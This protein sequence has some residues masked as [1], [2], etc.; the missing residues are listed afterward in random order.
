MGM[1]HV[2]GAP[3]RNRSPRTSSL[4]IAP[5]T[6]I[7]VR[8]AFDRTIRDRQLRDDA[9]PDVYDS[10]L[11]VT[12]DFADCLGHL[13]GHAPRLFADRCHHALDARD[14]RGDPLAEARGA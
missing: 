12:V 7:V 9:V 13:L 6:T 4:H 1:C 14:R 11:H 3:T 5:R 2:R 10:V 8:R